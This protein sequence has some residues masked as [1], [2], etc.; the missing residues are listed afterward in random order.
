LVATRRIWG[1][2]VGR[3]AATG[4]LPKFNEKLIAA[5]IRLPVDLFDE[6]AMV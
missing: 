3:F 4:I 1:K 5:G 2:V 6:V